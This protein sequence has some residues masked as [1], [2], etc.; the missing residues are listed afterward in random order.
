MLNLSPHR[1]RGPRSHMG[2][3]VNESNSLTSFLI[4]LHFP[5]GPCPL[6]PVPTN[7]CPP[8]WYLSCLMTYDPASCPPPWCYCP[9]PP[10]PYSLPPCPP[11][12]PLTS[13]APPMPMPM[14]VPFLPLVPPLTLSHSSGS[15]SS[16]TP[17]RGMKHL[18]VLAFTW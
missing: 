17:A 7:P 6:S 12:L 11:P 4:P 9:S 8:P 1:C 2:Q 5:P 3:A 14:P 13:A 16:S 18:V 15:G 10:A